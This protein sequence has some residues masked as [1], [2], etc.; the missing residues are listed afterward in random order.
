MFIECIETLF[1]GAHGPLPTYQHHIS[2]SKLSKPIHKIP[3]PYF[4]QVKNMV[5][6]GGVDHYVYHMGVTG[7]TYTVI[8]HCQDGHRAGNLGTHPGRCHQAPCLMMKDA[9]V[10]VSE[11]LVTIG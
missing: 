3:K 10:A 6:F 4:F 8:S 1:L 9:L 5:T 2:D 11:W 7:T